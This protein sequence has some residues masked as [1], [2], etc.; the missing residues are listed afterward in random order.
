[1]HDLEVYSF[2]SLHI[3]YPPFTLV[4]EIREIRQLRWYF[5]NHEEVH[6]ASGK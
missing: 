4:H 5:K 3:S 6:T 1:M 2:V